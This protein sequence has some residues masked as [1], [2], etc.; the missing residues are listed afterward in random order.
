MMFGR[1]RKTKLPELRPNKS[2][3]DEGIRDWSQKFAGKMYAD[4]QRRA[5]KPDTSR[6]LNI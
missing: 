1:E 6:Y 3:L 5:G 4:N 2:I